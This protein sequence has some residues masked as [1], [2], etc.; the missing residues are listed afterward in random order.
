MTTRRPLRLTGLL[1]CA[2]ALS[3]A[4]QS[5]AADAKKVTLRLD[6]KAYGVHAPFAWA[7]DRGLYRDEGLEVE[8]LEGTGSGTGVKLIANGSDTFG[9]I[10]YSIVA[11]GVP[12]LIAASPKRS[13]TA[14]RTCAMR[15]SS[16]TTS[17]PL[18]QR[19][20]CGWGLPVGRA[21]WSVR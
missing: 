5:A 8:L 18:S 14:R 1:V 19:C 6:W 11:I 12:R 21:S 10:D 2:V 16:A 20:A 9:L 4:I 17:V 3:V 15:S 7:I 13:S